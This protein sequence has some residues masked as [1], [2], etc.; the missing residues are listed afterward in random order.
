MR[1]L[2]PLLLF[3]T[4]PAMAAD[5]A[6]FCADRPGLTTGTCTAAAGTF[7][8]ESSFI[9]WSRSRGD[10][11]EDEETVIG[12][13]RLRY[14]I[15]D[16]TDIHLTFDPYIRT[17]DSGPDGS[18][19]DHGAGDLSVAVKHRFT[20]D[21]APLDVAVMCF[22]KVPTA[23]RPIGNRRWE[24]GLLLPVQAELGGPLSLTLTP[25]ID[26]N[27]DGDGHGHHAA[28]SLAAS[29]GMA[30]TTNLSASI[31]GLIA[32]ERDG[33]ATAHEAVAA[34]SLAYLA[35]STVQLD[36]QAAFGL[37]HDAADVALSSGIAFRF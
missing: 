5:P 16:R 21:D 36:V 1:V 37:S 28:W 25:E 8:L 24:G 9:D 29:L 23:S 3:A 27:A 22:V 11:E 6:E 10:G 19:T 35:S 17:H 33:G 20:P 14:G 15:D 26:W 2:L 31:D 32:R 34:M 30:I 12:S 7:Q 13:S 4:S 18:H